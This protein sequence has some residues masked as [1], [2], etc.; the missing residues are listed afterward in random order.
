M[1]TMTRIQFVALTLMVLVF[2]SGI[3]HSSAITFGVQAPRGSAKALKK[4]SELG[5]Y[6]AEEIGHPVKIVPL[7]PNKTVDAVTAGKAQ[8][9]LSNPALA[10][11]LIEK[12]G[13]TALATLEK[14]FG[15]QLGGVILSKKDSGINTAQD[16]KG[17][18]VMAFK[19]KKSAA[20]YIFQVKHL[21]N[22]GIDPYQD[23]KVFKE[24]TK[25]QDDIVLAVK[26]GIMDAGFVK[27]GLMEAMVK[28]G[29]ISMD[30]FNIV[31]KQSDGFALVH[32]TALYPAWTVTV[33]PSM[34]KAI[35][36]KVKAALLKM[37]GS[38]KAS[39]KAKIVGFVEPVSL[40]GLANTLKELH[41]P[42]FK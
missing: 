9:M 31:D 41:L 8:F 25:S 10:I 18:K 6:L 40:D 19:F 23:F 7:K 30:D 29:K 35:A 38:N 37:N 4:W 2:F 32:T 5:K 20:A 3:V 42:P 14:K 39:K 33:L 36:D 16:L 17:K 24:T 22:Q 1:K 26:R 21:K 34:D 11:V 13:S 27:T 15:Y 12:N 28:E